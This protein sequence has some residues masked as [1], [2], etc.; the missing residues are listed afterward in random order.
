MSCRRRVCATVYAV[1]AYMCCC[2]GLPHCEARAGE[3]DDPRAL[4]FSG[5]DIWRN[6]AFAY[7]GFMVA[8]GGLDSDGLLLKVML[9]GG[10]YR[11]NAQ[12]LNG[13]RVVGAEGLAQVLPGWRLKRGDAEFKVF[14]GPEIQRHSLSPDDP[15]NRLRGTS[16]GLRVAAEVWCE[17]TPQ[18]MIAGDLSL[19]SIA[20]SNAARLAYGWRVLEDALG[21]LFIGPEI[22]YFGS[23]GYR[24]T[25]LG[26]HITSMKAEDTEWSAAVGWAR[27]SDGRSS[28]Y[29]RLSILTRR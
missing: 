11:Y 22:Q 20:T 24:H 2:V 25:R 19:S 15:G 21:G 14:M 23:D 9:S 1:A 27:D 18:T 7:G 16:Y 12:N 4:L 10:L 6:G 8:P 29:V 17:P 28:P 13:E 3:I 5:R 26:A